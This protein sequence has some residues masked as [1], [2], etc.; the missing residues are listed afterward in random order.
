MIARQRKSIDTGVQ[1][2]RAESFDRR[3]S[4]CDRTIRHVKEFCIWFV[5]SAQVMASASSSPAPGLPDWILRLYASISFFNLDTS[6]VVHP[7]C[8][9]DPTIFPSFSLICYKTCSG[10][11]S[12]IIKLFIYY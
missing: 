9:P 6:Y 1:R 11:S 7:D 2:T 5:L 8:A 4:A 3:A 10:T 12:S